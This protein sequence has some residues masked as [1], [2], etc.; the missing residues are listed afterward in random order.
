[1]K[2][3]WKTMLAVLVLAIAVCLSTGMTVSARV[4]TGSFQKDRAVRWTV[5]TETKTITFSGKGSISFENYYSSEV[6]EKLWDAKDGYEIE[7]VVIAD[8]L[9]SLRWLF[10]PLQDKTLKIGKDAIDFPSGSAYTAS[11][12]VDKRNPNFVMY[13]GCV[14]TADYSEMLYCP[15]YPDIITLH[16]DVQTLSQD[17]LLNLYTASEIKVPEDN[18]YFAL[19]D[20]CL[21]TKDFSQVVLVPG[22]RTSIALPAELKTITGRDIAWGVRSITLHPDNPYLTLYNGNLYTK[23]CTELLYCPVY[24]PDTVFHPDL[25]IIG[26]RALGKMEGTYTMII[27]WGVTTLRADAAAG[28]GEFD[29][30]KYQI[31]FPDTITTL[32]M[33]GHYDS[34]IESRSVEPLYSENNQRLIDYFGEPTEKQKARWIPCYPKTKKNGW[35]QLSGAWY[36]YGPNGQILRNCWVKTKGSWYFLRNYNFTMSTNERIRWGDKNYYT[37]ADGKMLTN[38]WVKDY[39][40][41]YYLKEDGTKATSRWIL[42]QNGNWYYVGEYGQIVTNQFTPDG[43]YVDVNGVWVH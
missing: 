5:N 26:C 38:T 2:K 37:G 33:N 29:T 43:Y 16:P 8:G 40:D 27:P 42:H 13:D 1:M 21:Y 12:T 23:D 39:G 32:A 7:H 20:H 31:A 17:A 19:Y 28:V 11:I 9:V 30:G 3:L 24:H 35:Q 25:K 36:C 10:Y 4:Y 41:W 34:I 18:K 14:Y 22:N 6:W 15:K